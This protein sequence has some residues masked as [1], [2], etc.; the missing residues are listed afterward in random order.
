MTP[1][2]D[3]E[4]IIESLRKRFGEGLSIRDL[5]TQP[6]YTKS[7]DRVP[8]ALVCSRTCQILTQ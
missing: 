7:G 1:T 4:S 2:T 5:F 6:A 8:L 3:P